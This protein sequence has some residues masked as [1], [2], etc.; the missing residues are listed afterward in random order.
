MYGGMQGWRRQRIQSNYEK[1]EV[2][3]KTA[4]STEHTERRNCGDYINDGM[5]ENVLGLDYMKTRT[6]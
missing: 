6:C 1:G 4:G 2:E 5:R 3:E